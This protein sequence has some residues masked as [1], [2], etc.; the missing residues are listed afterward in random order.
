MFVFLTRGELTTIVYSRK[1]LV[2]GLD[3]IKGWPRPGQTVTAGAR[4]HS[5]VHSY[6][7]CGGQNDTTSVSLYQY[8]MLVGH[9]SH[10]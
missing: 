1:T 10:S 3:D 6:G 9:L 8:C 5:Q 4:V 7:I 2:Y